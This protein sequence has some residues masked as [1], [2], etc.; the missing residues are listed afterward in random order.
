MKLSR[1]DRRRLI[2]LF[3]KNLKKNLKRIEREP[4]KSYKFQVP[5]TPDNKNIF[6][7]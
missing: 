1:P 7:D 5:I 6:N 2:K 3:K 4:N